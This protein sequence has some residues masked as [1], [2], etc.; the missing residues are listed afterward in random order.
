MVLSVTR[1]RNG[2]HVHLR[3]VAGLTVMMVLT[4]VALVI[5][6][7]LRCA[8]APALDLRRTCLI[9]L[10]EDLPVVGR[11]VVLG[12]HVLAPVRKEAM[13]AYII[14][15]TISI[16]HRQIFAS[17]AHDAGAEDGLL[18]AVEAAVLLVGLE[19]AERQREVQCCKDVAEDVRG[20]PFR[21]HP[22]VAVLA[23]IVVFAARAAKAES[24]DGVHVAAVAFPIRVQLLFPP[25]VDDPEEL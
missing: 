15:H 11:M 21:Q 6:S 4:L 22:V 9:R 19:S 12:P 8:A 14:S 17:R 13:L 16:T 20:R 23:Q 7:N 1:P 5:I 24:A 3:L 25:E 2:L 10:E 18:R